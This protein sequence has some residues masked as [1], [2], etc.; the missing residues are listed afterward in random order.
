MELPINDSELSEILA[1]LPDS[2]VRERLSL[3]AQ[4]REENPGGPW[5]KI[6][7]EK[8]GMVI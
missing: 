3:I 4:V 2:P 1:V 7:R 6:L 8:H 5:K